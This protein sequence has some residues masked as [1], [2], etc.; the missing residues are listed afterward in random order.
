MKQ[1]MVDALEE[2]LSGLKAD[3]VAE[4]GRAQAH[5]D[6]ESG[7]ARAHVDAAAGRVQAQLGARL[8]ARLGMLLLFGE[9]LHAWGVHH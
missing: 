2:R 8:G 9:C 1:A 3:L 4:S 6:D 5:A 7:R